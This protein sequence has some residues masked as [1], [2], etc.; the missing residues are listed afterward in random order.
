[1]NYLRNIF[2]TTP[3]DPDEMDSLIPTHIINQNEL[4]EWEQTNITSA[5]LWINNKKLKPNDILNEIFVKKLHTKMFDKTWKWAGKFRKSN[6]NIGVDW[7]TIPIQ[8]R[9]LLNDV[10]YQAKYDTYHIDEIAARFH[11][12]LVFI[13]PFVNGNGRFSRLI[14]DSFLLSHEQKTFS[15]GMAS[16]KEED[17]L[18]KQY[19]NALKAADKHDYSLL[20]K[21]IRT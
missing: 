13:H 21:F 2:G 17:A 3:I 19:I 15:W 20:L 4:N 6:K 8:L 9:Q 1:M 12:R 5:Q 16:L 7:H 11:H 18:R 10:S 14:T